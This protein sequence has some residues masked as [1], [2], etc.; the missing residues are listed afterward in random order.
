MAS[1]TLE[2]RNERA[3]QKGWSSYGQQRYWM[4]RFA[5]DEAGTA[6]QLADRICGGEQHGRGGSYLCTACNER[7]NP[8]DGAR[9]GEW[10]A[11]LVNTALH[12]TS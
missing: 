1:D 5:L 11:R 9:R 3:R 4:A 8:R 10:Q 7:V 6:R 2:R 12:G